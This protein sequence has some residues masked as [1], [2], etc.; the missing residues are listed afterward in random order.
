MVLQCENATINSSTT[1]FRNAQ[2]FICDILIATHLNNLQSFISQVL[3]A[4]SACFSVHKMKII[5][6]LYLSRVLWSSMNL[7]ETHLMKR[8]GKSAKYLFWY[9]IDL[10]KILKQM[11]RTPRWSW[12]G[13]IYPIQLLQKKIVPH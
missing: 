9:F 3:L 6:L 1:Q 12:Y 11:Y 2:Y 8:K 10:A 4:F 5:V 7:S 13:R